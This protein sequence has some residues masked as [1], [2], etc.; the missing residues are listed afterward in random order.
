MAAC[1]WGITAS[2][3][4]GPDTIKVSGIERQFFD[5]LGRGVPYGPDDGT[6]APWAVVASLPFAPEIVLPAIDYCIHQV[7]LTEFNPYGFKATFNPTYPGQ[8]RQS[9]WL[10]ITMALRAQSRADRSDD[11][12]LSDRL[13]VAIDATL[14]I[15]RQRLAASGFWRGLVTWTLFFPSGYSRSRLPVEQTSVNSVP[16]MKY[17]ANSAISWCTLAVLRWTTDVRRCVFQPKLRGVRPFSPQGRGESHK[18]EVERQTMDRRIGGGARRTGHAGVRWRHWG[19]APIVRARI[20]DGWDLLES[21]SKKN[22]TR[23]MRA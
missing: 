14:P 17:T 10:G 4:P 21:N 15:H 1:C 2:D 20:C 12:K 23:R 5:Y 11:R 22:E 9:L 8:I 7:K 16:R 19:N 3:G 6:I 13:V 18:M